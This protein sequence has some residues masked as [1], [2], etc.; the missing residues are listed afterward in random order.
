MSNG[1]KDGNASNGNKDGNASNG[2]KDGSARVPT[3]GGATFFS[4]G[5]FLVNRGALRVNVRARVRF[6]VRNWG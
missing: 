3:G 2:N 5:T 1:N 6:G 4:T